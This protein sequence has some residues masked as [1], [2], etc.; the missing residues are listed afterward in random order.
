MA[1]QFFFAESTEPSSHTG[2]VGWV[3]KAALTITPDASSDY[4]ILSSALLSG[5]NSNVGRGPRAR[6]YHETAGV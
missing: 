6:T 2:S 3:D 5:N 1:R 4:L